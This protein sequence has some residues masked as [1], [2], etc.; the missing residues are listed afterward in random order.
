MSALFYCKI[1]MQ[2]TTGK[3]PETTNCKQAEPLSGSKNQCFLKVYVKT[4]FVYLI[5]IEHCIFL[6]RKLRKPGG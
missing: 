3:M 4:N 6:K 2:R 1:T 5:A